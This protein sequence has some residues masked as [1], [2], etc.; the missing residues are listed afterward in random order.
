MTLTNGVSHDDAHDIVEV[1]IN[2]TGLRTLDKAGKR[3][4][5]AARA[6]T[7]ADKLTAADGLPANQTELARNWQWVLEDA[8]NRLTSDAL[9]DYR[10][11]LHTIPVK[12]VLI[13]AAL[14]DD[15]G[16]RPPV[17]ASAKAHNE[18][19]AK[20]RVYLR[21]G[22]Y[23]GRLTY[24]Q[25]SKKAC[26][27]YFKACI[28]ISTE[29]AERGRRGLSYTT[30][31]KDLEYL[32]RAVREYNENNNLG[33]HPNVDIPSDK[34]RRTAYLLRSEAARLLWVTRGR[35]WNRETGTWV[36]TVATEG[37]V[38]DKEKGDWVKADGRV[39]NFIDKVTKDHSNGMGRAFRVEIYTGWR[40]ENMFRSTWKRH[41][42]H[43]SIDVETGMVHRTGYAQP[44]NTK[45]MHPSSKMLKR[46][47]QHAH[48]WKKAD[49]KEGHRHIIRKRDGEP[50]K[51]IH[52]QFVKLVEAAG[53]DHE[54]L[55]HTFRHT[56][57]TWSAIIGVDIHSTAKLMGMTVD[58]LEWVYQH[59]APA[60][61]DNAIEV[62]DDPARRA[63]LRNLTK[64]K[65][66]ED[67]PLYNDHIPMKP[68]PRKVKVLQRVQRARDN[69]VG[70]AA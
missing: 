62:W 53:L 20:A 70:R 56:L 25:M 54:I 24:G 36:K 41:P 64:E 18:W 67:Y 48:R 22:L 2:R 30:I 1:V 21:I 15:L 7:A 34:V 69:D 51:S 31:K 57:A 3:A 37:R 46:L 66:P 52:E 32:Q 19:K 60:S 47:L 11:R 8:A 13:G 45:N 33:F 35:V 50:Y 68:Q 12:E 9:E 43:G 59:F 42:K 39:V 6:E 29:A 23:F 14:L 44:Q 65:D 26:A 40:S 16:P 10:R 17:I 38:W 49:D 5:A 63:R 61:E 55:I 28:A 27:G 4:L 58:T